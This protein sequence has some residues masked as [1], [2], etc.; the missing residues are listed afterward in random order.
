MAVRSHKGYGLLQGRYPYRAHTE[1]PFLWMK[2]NQ[3]RPNVVAQE[4]RNLTPGRLYLLRLYIGDGG[5]LTAG[6]SQDAERAVDI[7]IENGDLW[8]DWYRTQSFKDSVYTQA[9]YQLPP[10]SSQNYYY[11]KVPQRVFRAK[12]PTARL[13]ISDWQDDSA[14]GGPVG[15]E[16]IFNNIDL[17]PY[18]E[19]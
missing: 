12:G 8:N 6:T 14:P 13:V 3:A 2:R 7:R 4:I 19:P 1:T 10:F 17:H 9:G 11:F 18:L 15:Q 16:L 5:E